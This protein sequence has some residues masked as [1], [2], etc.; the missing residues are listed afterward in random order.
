MGE[1][2]PLLL[3]HGT[4]AQQR[5]WLPRILD[6]SEIWC[7]LFSEPEAGSD[8]ASLRT[9]AERVDGG[10]LVSGQKVWT[11]YAQ[12]ADWGVCLARTDPD[13]RLFRKGPALPRGLAWMPLLVAVVWPM[14]LIASGQDVT[15]TLL[16][17]WHEND[18]VKTVVRNTKGDIRK[19][20]AQAQ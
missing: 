1:V 14:A 17:I 10:F 15:D 3:A 5:R 6:A 18:L 8:L 9:K 19:K 12:F 13:A 4:A 2:D 7:Q 20:R 16:E 11:S